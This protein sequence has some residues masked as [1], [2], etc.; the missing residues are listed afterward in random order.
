[1]LIDL[2]TIWQWLQVGGKP[3]YH[4]EEKTAD[5]KSEVILTTNGRRNGI[6]FIG[7]VDH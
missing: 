7:V 6:I 2:Q 1:M 3:W 4:A 5:E